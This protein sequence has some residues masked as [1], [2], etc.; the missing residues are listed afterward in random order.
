MFKAKRELELKFLGSCMISSFL[1]A[2]S[3]QQS[4]AGTLQLRRV[5]DFICAGPSSFCTLKRLR[6][7]VRAASFRWSNQ[8]ICKEPDHGRWWCH[9][10]SQY[11]SNLNPYFHKRRDT[12]APAS[13]Y[14]THTKSC[15]DRF[16]RLVNQETGC[17]NKHSMTKS[18]K[19][20]K[21]K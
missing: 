11:Q 9:Y 10:V 1:A 2:H 17:D 13:T 3:N 15:F 18:S 14:S 21:R 12:S 20:Y 4:T 16:W 7:V 19:R 6:L 8:S 5:S